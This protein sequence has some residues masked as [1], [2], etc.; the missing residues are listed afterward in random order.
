[1]N[2]YIEWTILSFLNYVLVF[3]K[4]AKICNNM[5]LGISMMGVAETMN[6]GIK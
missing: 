6:L 2:D 3:N 5:M 4:A 1:M